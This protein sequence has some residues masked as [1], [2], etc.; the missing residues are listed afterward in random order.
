MHGVSWKLSHKLQGYIKPANQAH[1]A[2]QH[3]RSREHQQPQTYDALMLHGAA[4]SKLSAYV[5]Y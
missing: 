1:A 2:P 4:A 5:A 3:P